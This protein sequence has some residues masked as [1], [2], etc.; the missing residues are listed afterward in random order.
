MKATLETVGYLKANPDYASEL[1][2]QR[3]KAPRDVAEKAV[4]S[5]SQVLTPS[6]RGSGNDLAAGVSGNWRFII[7]SGAV[8]AGP[9]VKIEEVVDARFLPGSSRSAR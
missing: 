6:G 9:V 4:A 1:Y 8:A 5:L 2:V 7:E 3:T